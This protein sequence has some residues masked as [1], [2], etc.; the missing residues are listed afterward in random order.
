M[1]P[2]EDDKAMT[3]MRLYTF[4]VL[5]GIVLGGCGYEVINGHPPPNKPPQVSAIELPDQVLTVGQSLTISGAETLFTDDDPLTLAATSSD[6]A[7]VAVSLV[8]F[9]STTPIR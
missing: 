9:G 1:N 2:K 5:A 7:V 3:K 6:T 4:M 8:Q